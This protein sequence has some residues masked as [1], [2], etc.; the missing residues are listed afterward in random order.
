MAGAG[1]RAKNEMEETN[2]RKGKVVEARPNA[3]F[4]VELD[5]QRQVL[6]HVAARAR[7]DFLRLLPGD[8]IEVR[9]SASDH[10]RGRIV[11]RSKT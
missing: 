2:R 1:P 7:Q 9:L 10:T 8:E 11:K 4:R 6:A 5:N 3:L